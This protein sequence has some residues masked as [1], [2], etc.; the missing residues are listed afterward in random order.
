MLL[1]VSTLNRISRLHDDAQP[2]K[3]KSMY[4]ALVLYPE[5]ETERIQE[6][7]REYD[8]TCNVMGPHI[9]VVFPVPEAVGEAELVSHIESVLGNRRAFEIGL[10]GLVK[11]NDHWLFLTL[12]NGECEVKGLYQAL[13]TGILAQ[14]RRDDIEFVAHL[15]LGLFVKDQATYDWNKPQESDFDQ[16]KYDAAMRDA[17]TLSLDSTW[18]ATT[19]HLVTVPDDVLQWAEG[20]RASFSKDSCAVSVREFHLGSRSTGKVAVCSDDSI[21]HWFEQIREGDSLAVQAVWE[22]YFPELVRLAREKLRGTP[23]RV[24]DEEDIAASVMESLF[25]AAKKGRFSDLANRHDLWRL[26]LGMTARKVVDLKRRETRQ[27]RG[28]GRV[29]GESVFGGTD[30]SSEYA[31]LA[32]I[33]GDAP[34]PEFAAMVAE[35]CQRLL[36]LLDEPDLETLAVAKMEGYTNEE[37]AKRLGCSVRTVERRLRLIRK[38]WQQEESQ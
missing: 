8:P 17:E 21:T 29:K 25:R 6:I 3:G 22:R 5:V 26:L 36:K 11:S 30:S 28:G 24:A 1:A 33:I 16:Q 2:P 9:T 12:V 19:L 27:R 13:Y 23:R 20:E 38:K 34:T 14:Y 4:Y 35:E 31:G 15:G 18:E 7:R 32:E 37:I 10:G